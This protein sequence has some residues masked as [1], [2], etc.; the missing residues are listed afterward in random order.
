MFLKIEKCVDNI[1][2]VV[3]SLEFFFLT[4]LYKNILYIR[5]N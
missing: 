5:V 4:R 2:F 3:I 1:I